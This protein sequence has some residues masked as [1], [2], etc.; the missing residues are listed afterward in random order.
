MYLGIKTKRIFINLQL[1]KK[2]LEEIFSLESVWS[3]IKNRDPWFN[4]GAPSD[5]E[6]YICELK[7]TWFFYC[8]VFFYEL[9]GCGFEPICSHLNF[10]FRSC[11]KQGV[12]W[13]SGNYRVLIHSER[14]AWLDENIQLLILWSDIAFDMN[15][16][17]V[18]FKYSNFNI[19]LSLTWTLQWCL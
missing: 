5:A 16:A 13:H 11:F 7:R 17:M 14:H 1:L 3:G 19:Q 18:S 6:K 12:P 10:I 8:W 9:S 2:W 4:S 15:T